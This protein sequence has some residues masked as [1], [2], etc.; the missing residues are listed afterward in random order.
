MFNDVEKVSKV[1]KALFG[2]LTVSFFP[3]KTL[4][5]DNKAVELEQM[6]IEKGISKP[7]DGSYP[8]CELIAYTK[9]I[10]FNW[11]PDVP[12][13]YRVFEDFWAM[14]NSGFEFSEAYK[15]YRRNVDNRVADEWWTAKA[16]AHKIWKPPAEK[17]TAEQTAEEASD[18]NSSG[19]SSKKDRK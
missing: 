16:R 14:I 3:Y 1:E 6:L 10:E 5:Y 19:T 12:E 18:P 15:F 7:R 11:H 4:E 9:S 8:I 2:M 13:E 17:P